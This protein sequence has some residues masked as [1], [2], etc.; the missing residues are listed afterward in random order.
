MTTDLNQW[1]SLTKE[2]PIDPNLPICDPHH[3]LWDRPDSTYLLED[4]IADTSS[5]H[6]IV[7]TV[8]LECRAEYREDGPDELRPLGETEFVQAVADESARGGHGPTKVAHGIVGK[9]DLR[10]G[11]RATDVLRAHAEISPNRF[12]GIRHA[13]A[14]SLNPSTWNADTP[15]E[16]LLGMADFREGFACLAPLGMIYDTW[17][18]HHQIPELTD[19]ATAFPETPIMLDHI[20]GPVGTDCF[21]G[22]RDEVFKEWSESISDLAT[23]RNVYVKLGGLGMPFCGFGWEQ[24][25]WPPGSEVLAEAMA[26]YF[27]HC[28]E[29]F[30]VDRCMFESNFPVDKVSFSYAVMWNAFKRIAADTSPEDKDAL[31]RGTARAFYRLD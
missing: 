15:P 25:E 8:F 20:G 31:F 3:H 28:I 12:R 22:K 6:N 21:E 29:A 13:A 27:L 10:L 14:R 4:L 19:L 5:G 9:V 16:G 18:Y 1:L 7:E 2:E 24:R 30:G 11:E 17:M 23:C 26:P